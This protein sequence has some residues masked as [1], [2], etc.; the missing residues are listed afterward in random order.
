MT[1]PRGLRSGALHML[2]AEFAEAKQASQLSCV[3]SHTLCL[4]V[5]VSRSI[6]VCDPKEEKKQSTRPMLLASI[7]RKR[8]DEVDGPLDLS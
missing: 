3:R 4:T 1:C 8:S 2:D 6:V 7:F 5:F